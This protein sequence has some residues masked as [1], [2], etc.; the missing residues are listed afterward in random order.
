MTPQQYFLF[1]RDRG[2]SLADRCRYI[3]PGFRGLNFGRRL[4]YYY[5]RLETFRA[6]P[7]YFK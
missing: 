2:S 6:W 4:H 7:Y 3:H 1:L 5:N